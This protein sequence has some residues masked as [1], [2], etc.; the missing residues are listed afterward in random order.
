[1]GREEFRKKNQR[2]HNVV[3]YF[4]SLASYFSVSKIIMSLVINK[5]FE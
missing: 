2:K 3:E 4:H 1:M 5:V